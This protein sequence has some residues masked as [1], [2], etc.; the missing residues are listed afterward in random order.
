VRRTVG[1][2]KDEFQLDRKSAN[3]AEVMSLLESAG[4][5]R[6]NPYYIVPQGR[7]S[8]PPCP[9]TPL[10][11]SM[12]TAWAV[13]VSQVTALT[14]QKDQD[15][16]QTLKDVAGTKVYEERRAESKRIMD[17]TSE[18]PNQPATRSAPP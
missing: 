3:K 1:L 11:S 13:S 5:S 16:L 8:S 14:N 4:F 18:Q 7:V 9:F 6:S 10:A 15:R 17:D 2:K 12:L